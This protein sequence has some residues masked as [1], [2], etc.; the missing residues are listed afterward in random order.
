MSISLL[1][2]WLN[3]LSF[4]R[5]KD[6]LDIAELLDMHMD[7]T[8]LIYTKRYAFNTTT[9]IPLDVRDFVRPTKTLMD[10]SSMK[11]IWEE[12]ITYVTDNFE[13]NGILDFWQYPEETWR[14]GAGD[15]DDSGS[16]RHAKAVSNGFEVFSCVGFWKTNGHFF[17]ILIDK[18]VL[19]K[20]GFEESILVIENTTNEFKPIPYVGS[21]YSINYIFNHETCWEFKRNNKVLKEFELKA[22]VKK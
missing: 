17:N 12:K 21:D 15:C 22:R 14:L 9:A 7:R 6:D 16:Y 1:S 4:F 13:V 18:S 5:K 10:N 20:V 19:E 2:K 8:E 11:Q 3:F